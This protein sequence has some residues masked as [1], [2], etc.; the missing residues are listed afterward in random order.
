ML[1]FVYLVKIKN[2]GAKTITAIG[3]E[4]V[5]T[6]LSNG[7]EL[8]RHPFRRLTEIGPKK[9]KTVTGS[10]SK[11]PT[12]VVSVGALEKHPSRPFNEQVVIN[13]VAYADG[14][15]WKQASF[16]GSCKPSTQR[17]K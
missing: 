10:S 17:Q 8:S 11:P 13:C 3:W 14:S 12:S 15:V 16:A 1:P 6:D 9:E 7:K 5:F 2:T 4:H